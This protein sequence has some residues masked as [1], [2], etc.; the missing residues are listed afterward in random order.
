MGAQIF[1]GQVEERV[2]FFHQVTPTG[3]RPGIPGYQLRASRDAGR[4]GIATQ[5]PYV[6]VIRQKS[7]CQFASDQTGPT[8]Q[9]YVH[10]LTLSLL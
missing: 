6:M 1:S 10:V 3:R 5:D 9:N 7:R 2:S 4:L 8:R